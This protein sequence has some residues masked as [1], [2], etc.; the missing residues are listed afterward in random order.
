MRT[1]RFRDGAAIRPARRVMCSGND[2]KLRRPTPHIHSE[3]G[4]ASENEQKSLEQ[5]LAIPI[6]TF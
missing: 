5:S 1:G 3:S 6:E 4:A 2:G